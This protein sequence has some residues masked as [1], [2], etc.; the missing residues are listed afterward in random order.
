LSAICVET[1]MDNEYNTMLL[2]HD[3]TLELPITK[4]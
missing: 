1:S 4:K 2:M 3:I